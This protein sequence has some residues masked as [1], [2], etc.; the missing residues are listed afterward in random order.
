MPNMPIHTPAQA[1]SAVQPVTQP[2]GVLT[3]LLIGAFV[4]LQT[5]TA[6]Y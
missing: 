6:D 4:I 2:I 1:I 3:V 5:A